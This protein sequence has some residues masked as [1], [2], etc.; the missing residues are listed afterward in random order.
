MHVTS[1]A[2]APTSLN[3]LRNLLTISVLPSC[4]AIFFHDN[5]LTPVLL[6]VLLCCWCVSASACIM[7]PA[8]SCVAHT[9]MPANAGGLCAW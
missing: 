5:I 2:P 7:V 8:C 4:L 1:G 3:S 9:A 6:L